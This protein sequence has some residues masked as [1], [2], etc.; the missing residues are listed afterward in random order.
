MDEIKEYIKKLGRPVYM[1]YLTVGDP[2][3]EGTIRYAGAMIEAGADLLELGIP[4]SDPTAD[5]PVI[6]EAMERVLRRDDFSLAKIFS[7]VG[8]IHRNHPGVPLVFLTYANPVLTG[9]SGGKT[10]LRDGSKFDIEKNILIFQKHCRDAG[11]RGVVIPDL[12]HD[13]PEAEIFRR[14]SEKTG[15]YQN[16]MITPNTDEQ[17]FQEICALSRGFIYYV[18][19]LGVTGERK[20]FSPGFKKN[21]ARIQKTSGLPVI[22][23]FGFTEP[24]QVEPIRDAVDGVIVGSMNHRIIAEKSEEALPELIRLTEGFVRAVKN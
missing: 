19:S 21:I 3:Y 12:P 23:G 18:T 10:G 9:F 2:S 11:V 22:A 20:S 1:P 4:F 5:G 17:R 7:T 24:S 14:M 8:S 16:L 15:V 13:Q 6:Q